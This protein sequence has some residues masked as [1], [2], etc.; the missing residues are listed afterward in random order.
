MK[1]QIT[2]TI[3]VETDSHQYILKEHKLSEDDNLYEV[4]LGYYGTIRQ[5]IKGLLE[6]QIKSA[7]VTDLTS[8]TTY[9]D[10]LEDR[11]ISTFTR[12]GV[13]ELLAENENNLKYIVQLERKNKR[14]E[15]Q[16][17]ELKNESIKTV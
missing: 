12:V 8:L 13:K 16:L 10:D 6:K 5:L 3:F 15:N 7:T 2:D 17:K 14:L 9:L 1:L 11:I 4:I